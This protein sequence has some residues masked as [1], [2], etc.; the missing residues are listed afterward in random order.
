MKNK[1]S[2]LLFSDFAVL[3]GKNRV[4]TIYLSDFQ[5]NL[6]ETVLNLT[7]I[8]FFKFDYKVNYLYSFKIKSGIYSQSD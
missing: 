7:G 6:S 1:T 5:V 3:C 4:F 2:I 8:V